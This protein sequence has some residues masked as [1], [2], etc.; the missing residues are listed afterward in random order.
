MGIS[1]GRDFSR[2]F[3]NVLFINRFIYT[4]TPGN[5]VSN[6]KPI[7]QPTK[8]VRPP[9]KIVETEDINHGV[10]VNFP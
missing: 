9:N 10:P 7:P 4:E 5:A 6:T 8:A 3:V 2:E 1:K